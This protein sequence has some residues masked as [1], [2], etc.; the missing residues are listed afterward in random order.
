MCNNEEDVDI[1]DETALKLAPRVKRAIKKSGKAVVVLQLKSLHEP[2]IL[3]LVEIFLKEVSKLYLALDKLS[4]TLSATIPIDYRV[5]EN[6]DPP[7]L[8]EPIPL[9]KL[10]EKLQEISSELYKRAYRV[11]PQELKEKFSIEDIAVHGLLI[12]VTWR[13]KW[14]DLTF[15]VHEVLE[16]WE[17]KEV[18]KEVIDKM[19]AGFGNVE[20]YI[21]L[22]PE[23]T[24]VIDEYLIEDN[25]V[26]LLTLTTKNSKEER[27]RI[28]KI[29]GVQ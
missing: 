15:D 8:G 5:F 7:V 4:T 16:D 2:H 14:Q 21:S 23:D 17:L 28:E 9:E 22:P 27:E 12:K 20:V 26:L 11:L 1:W 25:S 29:I 6:G 10:E 18:V 19:L 24:L 13:S 3:P